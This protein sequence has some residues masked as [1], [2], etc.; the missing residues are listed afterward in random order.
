LS[1]SHIEAPAESVEAGDIAERVVAVRSESD[2]L[3]NRPGTP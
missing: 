3:A 1:Y 2:G